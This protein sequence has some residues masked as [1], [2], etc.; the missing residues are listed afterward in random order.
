M[1][2]KQLKAATILQRIGLASYD[3]RIREFHGQNETCANNSSEVL[4]EHEA[5]I[6]AIISRKKIPSEPQDIA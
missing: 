1:T 5:M 6:R 2:T 4:P 3:T